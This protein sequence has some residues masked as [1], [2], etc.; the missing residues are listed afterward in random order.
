M[1]G[2]LKA[3]ELVLPLERGAEPKL[4]R[5]DLPNRVAQIDVTC[6][7]TRRVQSCA[8]NYNRHRAPR[9][10]RDVQHPVRGIRL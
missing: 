8:T 10:T 1:R 5:G 6:N 9:P 2:H 3:H 7:A 4:L